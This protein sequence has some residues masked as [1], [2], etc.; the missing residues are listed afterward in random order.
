MTQTPTQNS[1]ADSVAELQLKEVN[2]RIQKEVQNLRS[3]NE[4]ID[5][6]YGEF[7]DDKFDPQVNKKDPKTIKE[8]DDRELEAISADF[9]AQAEEIFK[10]EIEG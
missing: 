5:K 9:I 1:K 6:D 8:D 2:E 3:L 7:L 10:D 4:S